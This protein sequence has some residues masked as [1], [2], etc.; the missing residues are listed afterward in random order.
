M[1]K[2]T[3]S[4]TILL[5][6]GLLAL[7]AAGAC[8]QKEITEEDRAAIISTLENYLPL[9]AE[10][11]A[12]GDLEPLKDLAS[13]REVARVFTRVSELADE[14]KYVQPTFH[15]M[16]VEEIAPLG[17]SNVYVTALEVWDLRVRARGSDAQL[18]EDLDQR[19]RVSYQ[20]TRRGGRWQ[21]LF[22]ELD[23]AIQ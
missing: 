3:P 16:T 13:E 15:R 9:L 17:R 18:G 21:V 6:S 22:R 2:R 12:T 8:G 7:V 5:A 4:P 1:W 11:Y 20:L 19:S 14:G 23:Q 10:S